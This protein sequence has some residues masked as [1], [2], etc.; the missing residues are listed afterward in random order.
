MGVPSLDIRNHGAAL[1]RELVIVDAETKKFVQGET[2]HALT[3][4]RVF[5][6]HQDVCIIDPFGSSSSGALGMVRIDPRGINRKFCAEVAFNVYD[7]TQIGFDQGEPIANWFSERV[8]RPCR[9]LR[10]HPD[11]MPQRELGGGKI[12]TV[13]G[14][15]SSS[16]H[17]V[18]EASL[19]DFARRALREIDNDSTYNP[20]SPLR[21]RP[22]ILVGGELEAYAE[23]GWKAIRIGESVVLEFRKK[24][25]RCDMIDVNPDTGEYKPGLVK[26]LN[27]Y[28]PGP[29]GP[30]L[31]IYLYPITTGV[32]K[33]GDVVTPIE[34]PTALAA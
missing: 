8:G 9:V 13:A 16:I 31:G 24:T 25:P 32:I 30:E 12:M 1:D 2:R 18:N 23:D 15:D 28:R 7:K 10:T 26:I 33:V 17:L 22:N 29:D 14:H 27:G 6:S 19:G 3:R 21:F 20:G 5:I 4:L 11:F 34:V